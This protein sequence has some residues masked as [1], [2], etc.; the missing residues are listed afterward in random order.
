MKKIIA[1]VLAMVMA[2]ALCT[3]AFATTT[4]T[5]TT[6]SSSTSLTAKDYTLLNMLG[7]KVDL[8]T[9]DSLSFNSQAVKSVTVDG[10]KTDYVTPAYYSI[11]YTLGSTQYTASAYVVDESVAVAKVVKGGA[12]VDFVYYTNNTA[13]DVPVDVSN[14]VTK[15]ITSV[16]TGEGECGEYETN[17]G[18]DVLYVIDGK[19]YASSTTPTGNY[20]L[21]NG[22]LVAY[23]GAAISAVKHNFDLSKLNVTNN[24]VTSIYCKNCDSYIPVVTKVPANSVD[25]YAEVT[26]TYSVNN[27]NTPVTGTYY[28]LVGSAAGTSTKADSAATSPKTFDAGIAMYVGMA[29]TSVAGSAVVIGKKK[30][31]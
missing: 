5:T 12:V 8:G 10:E 13:V 28:Y 1:T 25:E 14:V 15:T 26:V 9:I 23:D 16:K 18:D 2:L 22:K 11:K 20:A 7:K 17:D 31:F 4:S 30:E 29:L 6:A 27:S 21:L 19:V 24:T 3:T